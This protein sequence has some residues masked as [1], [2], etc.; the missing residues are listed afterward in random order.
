[1]R[2]IDLI[3]SDRATILAML[4]ES[5]AG[6]AWHGPSVR[7]SLDG[8]TARVAS[9]K[10]SSGRNSIWE[11]VLHL[12]H[13]RH[14]LIERI[15]AATGAQF[16]RPIRE[17][18]WPAG[19]SDTSDASWRRDVSLLDEYHAK[20]VDAIRRATPAQLERI[21]DGSEHTIARQLLGMAMHDT[22]HAGQIRLLALELADRDAPARRESL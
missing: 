14:L 3:E 6:P 13:G 4:N 2:S 17:P 21:P 9:S 15:A 8:V 16:P 11:L 22:Y 12:A 19:P 5:F 10:L 7:E 1:M 18:W 20:L